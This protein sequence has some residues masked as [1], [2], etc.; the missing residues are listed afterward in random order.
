MSSHMSVVSKEKFAQSLYLNY[1]LCDFLGLSG[2]GFPTLVFWTSTF[3]IDDV[4]LL[5]YESQ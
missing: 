2:P 4:L 3:G 5:F 1:Q